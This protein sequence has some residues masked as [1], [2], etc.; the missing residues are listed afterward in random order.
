MDYHPKINIIYS[1]E[2]SLTE[3][4]Y[5]QTKIGPHGLYVLF[6]LYALKIVYPEYVFLNKGNHENKAINS[7]YGFEDEVFEV[8]DQNIYNQIQNT[9]NL[10]PLCTLIEEKI[11]ILHG[12]LFEFDNVTLDEIE[13]YFFI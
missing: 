5:I 11:I 8:Y 12:G 10:L 13:K 7:R 1:T 3:V 6:L 2:I 9:F 4:T